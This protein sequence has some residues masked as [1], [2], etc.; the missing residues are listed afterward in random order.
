MEARTSL[1]ESGLIQLISIMDL[2]EQ[3]WEKNIFIHNTECS[4]EYCMNCIKDRN[5]L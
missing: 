5:L 3:L 1:P 4:E 2:I